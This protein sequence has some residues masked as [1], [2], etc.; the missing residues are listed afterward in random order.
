MLSRNAVIIFVVAVAEFFVSSRLIGVFG[1]GLT[2]LASVGL[3]MFGM[4]LLRR[5]L[6]RIPEAL[7][8]IVSPLTGA[9]SGDKPERSAADVATKLGLNSLGALLLILPGFLTAAVGALLF[10]PPVRALAGPTMAKRMQAFQPF[11]SPAA[12]GSQPFDLFERM[13]QADRRSDQRVV[14]V[15]VVDGEP[16]ADVTDPT[17]NGRISRPELH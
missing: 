14:D 15:D 17:S 16:G 6:G 11:S 4:A 13:R 12:G 3:A 9:P 2:L 10:L 7:Q 1:F 8:Q 5:N